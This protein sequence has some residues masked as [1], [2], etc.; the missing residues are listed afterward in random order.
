MAVTATYDFWV[1]WDNDDVDD[2]GSEDI[3]SRVMA[4]EWTL[5]LAEPSVIGRVGRNSAIIVLNNTSGDYNSYNS[6]SPI[7]GNIKPGRKVQISATD[8]S[9]TE[10]M[11]TG[12]LE[13][14]ESQPSV[15]GPNVAIL[16][17]VTPLTFVTRETV[18]LAIQ[19]DQQTGAIVGALLDEFGWPAGDRAIDTGLSSISYYSKD[20]SRFISALH[21]IEDTELGRLYDDR[22]GNI[23]FEDRHHRIKSPHQTSQATFSDA[24]G[25]ARTYTNITQLDPL[26]R[27]LN[28]FP[29]TVKTY[30]LPAA[31]AVLWEYPDT[32]SL[33]YIK[34]GAT[35]VFWAEY[36]NF[37]SPANGFI[38]DAWDT[39]ASTTDFTANSA[40][41]G[42]GTDL[43]ASIGISVD[44]FANAMKISLTN[45]H[46]SL[47]AFIFDLQARG[48]AVLENNSITVVN[49][50][51]TS[52]ADYGKR[53]H[54]TPSKWTRTAA[55]ANS[56]GT[57][58]LDIFDDPANIRSLKMLVHG[59][60]DATHLDEVLRRTISDRITL[61]A[62]NDTGLGINEDFYIEAEHHRVDKDLFHTVEWDLSSA[63]TVDVSTYWQWGSAQWGSTTKWYL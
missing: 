13:K 27:L 1:D 63:S 22:S 6:S 55:E 39:T 56:L 50:D 44:K 37:D 30:A 11:W 16:T 47:D 8:A 58:L 41:D 7:F 21:E 28:T 35:E 62:T 53:V 48:T 18:R 43:T 33:P 42:S 17:A 40:A 31:S 5:G 9:G 52:Q 32:G 4:A 59:N 23:V 19:K 14:L 49:E 2:G 26:P 61:V 54:R 60:R 10:T 24:G 36:P 34:F 15:H 38:V 12:R 57:Y 51:T 45:N 25:A 46:G 29:I 20:E 3:T